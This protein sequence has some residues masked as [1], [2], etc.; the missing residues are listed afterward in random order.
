MII[1]PAPVDAE[2]SRVWFRQLR[3]LRDDLVAGGAPA[4]RLAELSMGMSDD[5][6]VAIEEGATII[7]VGSAIFGER[8]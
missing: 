1:P 5:F 6:E 2:D 4:D 3:E 8:V 7:R